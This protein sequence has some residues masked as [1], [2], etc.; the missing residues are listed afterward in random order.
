MRCQARL[1]LSESCLKG[2]EHGFGIHGFRSTWS[3]LH[4]THHKCCGIK[5]QFK[6]VKYVFEL[7]NVTRSPV[8]L[9]NHT[10]S[11]TELNMTAHQFPLYYQ[12]RLERQNPACIEIMRRCPWCNGYRRRKWTRRH[13]FKSWTRQIAIHIVLIP[14][15]KVWIKL[16]S[17]QIWVNS[18]AD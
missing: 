9:S 4:Y 3:C 15:G 13:E 14:L 17:P 12:P 8:S 1:I 10:W 5:A 18:R 16:F 2:L 6:L 7:N 11:E